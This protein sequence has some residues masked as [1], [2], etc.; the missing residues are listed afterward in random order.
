MKNCPT[1]VMSSC[2]ERK[3]EED[4]TKLKLHCDK[5]DNGLQQQLGENLTHRAKGEEIDFPLKKKKEEE[6]EE[7]KSKVGIGPK[8]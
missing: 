3:C 5:T 6:E 7:V 8:I 4:R 1:K 2:A